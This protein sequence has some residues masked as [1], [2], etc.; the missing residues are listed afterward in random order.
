MMD[1]DSRVPLLRDPECMHLIP[2]KRENAKEVQLQYKKPL[3]T[4]AAQE[5]D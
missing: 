4:C 2:G 3:M 5:K 1:Y